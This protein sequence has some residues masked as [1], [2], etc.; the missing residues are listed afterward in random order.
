MPVLPS[1]RCL[2]LLLLLLLLF[3]V[4]GPV[5]DLCCVWLSVGATTYL[6]VFFFLRATHLHDTHEATQHMWS[7]YAHVFWCGVHL[8]QP[9][10]TPNGYHAFS[11]LR[12]E[13]IKKQAQPPN[14]QPTN[15]S[16]KLAPRYEEA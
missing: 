7:M 13:T 1:A 5:N 11:F 10:Q 16:R 4:L 8:Q 9:T 6:Y 2:L 14:K 3:F 12:S 15:Q